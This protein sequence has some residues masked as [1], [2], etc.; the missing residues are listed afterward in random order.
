M[1]RLK[2]YFDTSI[3]SH[4]DAPDVPEKEADTKRLWER[5]KAGE[6]EVFIS[7][8]V[9]VEVDNCKEPKRSFMQAELQ[10]IPHTLLEETAEVF[11]LADQYVAAGIL[12]PRDYND[13]LHIAFTRVYN[14]DM[15]ISWNFTHLVNVKTINGVKSVNALAGYDE[16]RIYPP[17]MLIGGDK[18]E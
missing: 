12:R 7:P 3:V 5:V 1:K 2:L 11:S 6:F 14:C 8:V 4:L 10:A 18:Y 15:L 16:T 13:C 17:T 9:T